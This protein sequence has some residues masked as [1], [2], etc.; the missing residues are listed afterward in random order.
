MTRI[1]DLE[2]AAAAKK[3][4]LADVTQAVEAA[5]KADKTVTS[6]QVLKAYKSGVT[7][8]FPNPNHRT[9]GITA[10]VKSAL[11]Q[12]ISR[13]DIM[14]ALRKGL[15]ALFAD[16]ITEGDKRSEMG[17]SGPQLTPQRH[18]AKSDR[19]DGWGKHS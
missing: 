18:A 11:D 9:A 10:A 5:I 19:V 2:V 6:E 16:E 17:W 13:E 1:P 12:G 7:P 4:A 8:T 15:E 14:P 3:T